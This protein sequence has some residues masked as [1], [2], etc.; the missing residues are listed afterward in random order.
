MYG[1]RHELHTS[2]PA[3]P[4]GTRSQ[5]QCFLLYHPPEDAGEGGKERC[6]KS[7]PKQEVCPQLPSVAPVSPELI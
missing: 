1:V 5:V 2:Y 4:V 3:L 6:G 7:K